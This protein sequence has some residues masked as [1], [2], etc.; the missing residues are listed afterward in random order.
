MLKDLSLRSDKR[1]NLRNLAALIVLS[2]LGGSTSA[3]VGYAGELVSSVML[4]PFVAPQLLSG[5]HVFWL[6]LAAMMVPIRGSATLAGA[7]KGLIEASLFSHLGLFSFAVSLL[8]G[9]VADVVLALL[10][11]NRAFSVYV[12][13]GLSSAS[14]LLIVQLFFLPSL[15]IL[16]YALAYFAAFLSGLVF[17]G[18]LTIKVLKVILAN[19]QNATSTQL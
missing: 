15:P 19:L 4:L 5:L 11:R 9:V 14:N 10:K 2:S 18:Y 6:I 17:G 3:L 12:A 16:I 8:E 1:N 13:G 7:L